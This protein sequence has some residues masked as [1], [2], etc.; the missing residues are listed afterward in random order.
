MSK[1]C[2]LAFVSSAH[3][4]TRDFL[5]NIAEAKDGRRAVAIWDD[6]PDRGR[7]FAKECGAR[8]EPDIDAMIT[9]SDI[10]GFVICA[11]NTRHLPLLEKVLPAGKPVMCEKPLVT[12]LDDLRRV[13]ELHSR[14]PTPL[15]C[16]YFMPFSAEMQ[17]IARLLEAGKLGRVTRIR[18]RS[19]H[20]GA[21]GRWFDNPDLAWF[22]NPELAGGGG[23]MDMGAHAIHLVRSLFGPV[24]TV[25]AMLRNQ[26]GN[27]P[28]VD[29]GGVAAFE[30]E[31]GAICIVEAGWT[32]SGGVLR[33]LEVVGS[34]GTLWHDG[35]AYITN[36]RKETPEPIVPGAARPD[37]IERLVAIIRG[38]VS[39]AALEKDLAAV[40]DSVAIMCA[41]HRSSN[42]DVTVTL[43]GASR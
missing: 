17:A 20:F 34:E 11:E 32:Q 9:A 30:M 16:G 27:Y 23:F 36:I 29:D 37:R 4:H 31:S 5:K 24:K 28:E 13:R 6:I 41:C 18:C 10:D 7:R 12:S 40:F 22:A 14:H 21:Y 1:R 38:E 43:K 19:A 25:H 33:E 15:F 2:N 39:S 35:R 42:E 3:I 8:F 26:S